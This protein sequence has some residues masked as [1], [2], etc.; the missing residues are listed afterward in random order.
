MRMTYQIAHSIGLTQRTGRCTLPVAPPGTKVMPPSQLALS[1]STSRSVPN[2]QAFN[3]RSAGVP[4]ADRY[5]RCLAKL[6]SGWSDLRL[7]SVSR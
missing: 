5:R 2:T 1:T 7:E 4:H 3:R 6:G